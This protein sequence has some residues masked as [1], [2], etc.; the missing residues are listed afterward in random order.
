MWILRLFSVSPPLPAQRKPRPSGVR[1]IPTCNPQPLAQKSP[2][3]RRRA[4]AS[5]LRSNGAPRRIA[6]SGGTLYTCSTT[7]SAVRRSTTKTVLILQH[8]LTSYASGITVYSRSP[9]F[10]IPNARTD[11]YRSGGDPVPKVLG[12][13]CR[14]YA[15]TVNVN[16]P[17]RV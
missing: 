9:V 10:R 5:P 11:Q 8:V 3:L 4:P 6:D 2:G 7:L 14:R 12:F 1:P 13:P 16:P 17:R 15:G